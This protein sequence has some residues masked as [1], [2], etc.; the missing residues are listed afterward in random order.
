MKA[1]EPAA[2][3]EAAS[4][5]SRPISR[6]PRSS[7]RAD[8]AARAPA[9]A[10]RGRRASR[11]RRSPRAAERPVRGRAGARR[12]GAAASSTRRSRPQR[13]ATASRPTTSPAPPTSTTSSSS[14]SR[15]GCATRTS[16]STP[17]SS[18]PSCATGSATARRSS[19]SAT[20]TR[21]DPRR[22]ASTSTAS[23][24]TRAFAAPALAFGFSFSILFREGVEAVLLIAILLGSLAAGRASELQAAAR[25]A[26]CVGGARRDGAHVG[27]RDARDRH[28]AGQP[29]AARGDH[30]AGRGRRAGRGQ[31]LARSRGSSTGAGM[32]FMRA[33]V[34]AAIAAGSAVAFA[35]ARLHRRLPRGLRDRA[36]LPGARA[37]RRG[38]RALGRARRGRRPR[39]RSAASAT[40]SSSSARKLPL[41][42]MLIAGASILLLLSVAFVGNAVR[43]LQEAD[44][45]AVTPDRRRLGAAARLR[46]RAHRA[47]TRRA[48]ASLAQAALLA[49]L[50]RSAPR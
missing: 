1:G 34:A 24:P 39:S 17:S 25:A 21:R 22:P 6:R 3:I 19:R 44:L 41:K 38:P 35:G 12:P 4:P 33:R 2:E 16:C 50:R 10:G 29:R 49:R 23:W 27:A 47:S 46:R 28:R 30:R 14:R 13:P 31:L 9:R 11:R 32:E 42:P 8:A 37:L 45:I 43:S 48:R 40:R 26:A 20:S 15:C 18:S 5:R 36:L 7:C